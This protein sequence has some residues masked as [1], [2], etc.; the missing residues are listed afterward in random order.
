MSYPDYRDPRD[1]ARSLKNLISAGLVLTLVSVATT[2]F[3]S[4]QWS[5]RPLC[6]FS[7]RIV[8]NAQ[9]MAPGKPDASPRMAAITFFIPI[10]NLFGPYQALAS[11]DRAIGGPER[12][13]NGINT[14][15]RACVERREQRP[16][17]PPPVPASV[18][19][20]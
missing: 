14:L 7:Y 2:L 8:A 15:V 13:P 19:S 4:Q 11:A 1:V 18:P 16:A 12:N 10:V 17:D 6:K 3:D 9:R 20:Y 5:I